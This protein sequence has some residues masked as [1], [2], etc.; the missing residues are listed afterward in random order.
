MSRKS[1]AKSYKTVS[2][3]GR[4]IT[5][6][7]SPSRASLCEPASDGLSSLMRA[8]LIGDINAVKSLLKEGADVNAKDSDGRTALMDATFAGHADVVTALLEKGADPDA[9]D[10][11]GWTALME[12]ASKGHTELVKILLAAGADASAE[13]LD[14]WTALAVAAKGHFQ[15]AQLL[16]NAET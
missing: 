7:D 4:A 14:R 9:K 13:S 5:I 2:E 3:S 16:R 10:K 1:A 12:A 15:I 6:A 11:D 8:S